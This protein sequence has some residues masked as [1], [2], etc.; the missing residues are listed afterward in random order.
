MRKILMKSIVLI[1]ALFLLM[2][3]IFSGC[4][5]DPSLPKSAIFSDVIKINIFP[6]SESDM[7]PATD[8][9]N[10]TLPEEVKYAIVELFDVGA[11]FTD[12]P[13]KTVPVEDLIAGSRT[14]LEA[15]GFTRSS[16]QLDELYKKN[17]AGTD[18]DTTA[19]YAPGTG[20]TSH[21]W[22]VLGYDENM[23]LTHASPAGEV[24]IVW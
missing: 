23:I 13:E 16:V 10:Y 18:F 6:E 11:V 5:T 14:G 2:I 7:I 4:S 8:S 17:A 22:I 12:N 1:Q 24:S 15:Y 9:F 20:L 21:K 19:I 3:L